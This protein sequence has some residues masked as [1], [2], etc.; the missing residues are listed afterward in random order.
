MLV[1]WLVVPMVD[2]TIGPL[3]PAV[4]AVLPGHVLIGLGAV[5]WQIAHVG[6]DGVHE[7]AVGAKIEL[8]L[9]ERRVHEGVG[10]D[11][12]RVRRMRVGM[13][14]NTVAVA[15]SNQLQNVLEVA[16]PV[17]AGIAIV[18]RQGVPGRDPAHQYLVIR[19]TGH[20][21]DRVAAQ[22]VATRIKLRRDH[23]ARV[24]DCHPRA[25]RLTA[26]AAVVQRVEAPRDIT[27]PR[28]RVRRAH[29]A[30]PVDLHVGSLHR[31]VH[32]VADDPDFAAL[33]GGRIV[34]AAFGE[35][36]VTAA[37]G[38]GPAGIVAIVEPAD[39]PQILVAPLA[40]VLAAFVVGFRAD[41][42]GEDDPA[43][44]A[45]VRHVTFAARFMDTEDKG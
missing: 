24:G 27:A 39:D 13:D 30:R 10:V 29:G 22:P 7:I 17:A 31:V 40:E 41:A 28:D 11:F 19:V 45:G 15:R 43:R 21:V 26:A 32:L 25:G 8:V 36:L 23:L 9:L 1:A 2:L 4:V 14:R 16:Y 18:G 12:I 38:N 44:L 6:G 3:H 35:A 34:G 42:F 37:M 33:A 20:A 5:D